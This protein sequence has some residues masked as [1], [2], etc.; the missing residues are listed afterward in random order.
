MHWSLT[1]LSAIVLLGT[2]T[3][4]IWYEAARNKTASRFPASF[5]GEIVYWTTYFALLVLGVTTVLAIIF[6]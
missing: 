6:R 2:A 1:T 3:A 5:V 4:M